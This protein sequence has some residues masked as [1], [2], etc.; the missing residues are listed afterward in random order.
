MALEFMH[1]RYRGGLFGVRVIADLVITSSLQN[2]A[3]EPIDQS[4]ADPF[5]LRFRQS[6][7]DNSS[8]T[9]GDRGYWTPLA[10]G[11]SVL[12]RRPDVSRRA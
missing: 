12:T 8:F 6:E 1:R 9:A 2:L 4:S 7:V 3:R 5:A 11:S 10:S